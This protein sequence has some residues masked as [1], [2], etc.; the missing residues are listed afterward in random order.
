MK[1]ITT[2]CFLTVLFLAGVTIKASEHPRKIIV[3]GTIENYES[4]KTLQ[5]YINKPC[6]EGEDVKVDV[7]NQGNFKAVFDNYTPTDVWILYKTNFLVL[8]HPGDSIHVVFDGKHKDRPQLLQDIRFEGKTA[9]INQQAAAVQKMFFSHPVYSD[10]DKKNKATKE[11]DV[12]QY[13]Q[14]LDTVKQELDAIYD[15]F[16][17]EYN[18]DSEVKTWASAFLNE[19]YYTRISFYA[20]DHRNQNGMGWTDEWDVPK[21]FYNPMLSFLPITRE[22]LI[23]GYALRT[24]VDRFKSY[25]NDCQRGED[26]RELY[27]IMPGGGMISGSDITDSLSISHILRNVNDSLLQQMMITNLFY[28]K[29]EKQDVEAYERFRD[30]REKYITEPFLKEPL[31][32]SYVEVKAR[33]ENPDIYTNMVLK[34][35]ANS[36][37]AQV[38]DSIMQSNKGKVIYIDFW[39]TWCAPCLGEFPNSKTLHKDLEGKDVAFVYICIE[40]DEPKWKATLDKYQLE[41]QHYL[42]DKKQGSEMRD[43]FDI[44][45]IPFYVLVG[46]DGVIQGT[47]SH[48][49]P[50]SVQGKIEEL[51]K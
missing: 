48:L 46:K 39:A 24:F 7:D 31:D 20:M 35:V 2:L 50:L 41:G 49:R 18:P 43:I 33:L 51:L 6:F 21:G 14:Y 22:K 40:S 38:M 27:A 10:W 23:N 28:R 37:A 16:V 45:G 19:S 4:G 1:H 34:D 8:V 30:V 11:Y 25:V 3:T 42:L 13:T 5:M 15:K 26:T 36:S 32:K 47:G 17:A 29:L 44:K 12:A 9:S